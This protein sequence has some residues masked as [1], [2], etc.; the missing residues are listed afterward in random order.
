MEQWLKERG[1]ERDGVACFCPVEWKDGF[2]TVVLGMNFLV[3]S[4]TTDKPNGDVVGEFWFAQ[5]G[6]LRVE[7]YHS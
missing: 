2:P 7:L 3:T 5:N 6:E 1:S 4:V